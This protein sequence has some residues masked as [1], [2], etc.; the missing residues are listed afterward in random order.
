MCGNRPPTTVFEQ[1]APGSPSSQDPTS[2]D[3]VIVHV[4]LDCF[5]AQVEMIRNPELRGKP[6]GVQ[7]KYLLV[8][9]NYVARKLGVDKMMLV[10]EAKEK[11]PE[12]ILV[13]GEDLSNYREVS[14][15]VTDLMEEFSPL[16]ERLGFDENFVDIT[17]MVENRLKQFQNGSLS[18]V[19]V[20]GHT[21]N[22]QS[23]NSNNMSHIRLAIGSQIA[24]EIRAAIHDRLDLT[25]CAGIASNKLIS[26]LVSGTF[27]PNQQT[28][29]L[30]ESVLT[31]MNSLPELRKVPGIGPGTARRL[32]SLAISN[33]Q[34]LQTFPLELLKKKVG[35][36]PA[37]RLHKLSYGED[38][39]PV[40]P[41]GPPQSHS[42]EDSFRRCSSEAEVQ[43]ILK[44]LVT[45][46][47]ERIN[48]DGRQPHTIR[49]TTRRFAPG[50]YFK[51]ESRQCQIPSHIV[52]KFGTGCYDITAPLVEILLKLFRKMIDVRLPFHITLLNVCFSK[53][54][55]TVPSFRGSIGFFLAQKK[56]SKMDSCQKTESDFTEDDSEDSCQDTVYSTDGETNTM[57]LDLETE[58]SPS[59]LPEVSE[60][61]P[62]EVSTQEFPFHNLPS[63]IDLQVF[64]QLPVDIQWEIITGAGGIK[65]P[66]PSVSKPTAPC[67]PK[68][69]NPS[70]PVSKT[71]VSFFAQKLLENKGA[72]C[73]KDDLK[74]RS[75]S[76]GKS[77]TYIHSQQ[78]FQN[79][80]VVAHPCPSEHEDPDVIIL[81]DSTDSKVVDLCV[82]TCSDV[83]QIC[84]DTADCLV[85]QANKSNTYYCSKDTSRNESLLAPTVQSP[86][87]SVANFPPDVD[88]SVFSELPV[89]LQTELLCEW[90]QR[91]PI[92]K[93]QVKK[94]QVKLQTS[95]GSKSS[96]T[97]SVQ[98][99]ILRYFKLNRT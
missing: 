32:A 67:S 11:C 98:T 68:H 57:D 23:F 19:T 7:Q 88:L 31:L 56:S 1:D 58:E 18:D 91:S 10:N 43:K 96:V 2:S 6:V 21:Y 85:T 73:A 15:K 60:K 46:L 42:D 66:F 75:M 50:V 94:H 17:E 71:K 34:D 49:L 59:P 36:T 95:K 45:N 24:A 22:N 63:G 89:D 27:K 38:D 83:K 90:K 79:D 8:T 74:P 53:L 4:D 87:K 47:L 5:Y 3:R 72:L 84:H 12:L 55:T 99:D 65:A 9:C 48:K 41:S 16:V 26:K 35:A 54:K 39:S 77:S 97:R 40:T 82:P 61:K 51:R 37:F 92:S 69:S 44:K 81:E 20:V 25:G 33:I 70:S 14:Y 30:P 29:L 52:Q 28:V 64:T 78:Q 13:N 93:L 80:N 86:S 76:P 62:S